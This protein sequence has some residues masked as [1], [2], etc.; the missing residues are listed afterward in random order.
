MWNVVVRDKFIPVN[1]ETSYLHLRTDSTVGSYDYTV[2]WY[3]DK[4]GRYTGGI[5]IYFTST[6]KYRLLNCQQYYTPFPTSL[7][8]EQ[9]KDWIIEKRSYNTKL[10]CNGELVLDIT[11]SDETCNNPKYTDTWAANWG[12]E[13]R[14]IKFSSNYD[15]ASDSYYIG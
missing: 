14:S 11:A 10:Y 9:D 5:G 15:T 4:E 3:Y 12:R 1:L 13:V 2:I 6:V 7:P 8:V